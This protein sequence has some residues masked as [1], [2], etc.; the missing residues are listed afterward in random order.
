MPYASV[1]ANSNRAAAR[2]PTC[3]GQRTSSVNGA[4]PAA[5]CEVVYEAYV[6][7]RDADD[8]QRGAGND[9]VRGQKADAGLRRGLRSTVRGHGV[10]E[11]GFVV[12]D[13]LPEKT[14][15]LLTWIRRQP[16]FGA[17]IAGGLFRPHHGP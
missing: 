17:A 13:A 12:V 6:L 10:G 7:G 5:R 3:T 16:C 2:S 14:A 11:A 9:G 8:D 1:K 15:S 4:R